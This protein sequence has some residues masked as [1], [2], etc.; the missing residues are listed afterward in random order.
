V[1]RVVFDASAILAAA[2]NEAG[3][4]IV[5]AGLADSAVSTVNL[6]EAHGKLIQRGLAPGDAW[7]AALSFGSEVFPF[8]SDQ[9]RAAGE[10]VGVTRFLGLSLGDRSCLALAML[11]KAP[12]YTTD[13]LWKKLHIGVD[14]HLLR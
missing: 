8:D 13:R 10:M 14:I 1:S 12:V 5:I 11:L 7:E 6:A 4:D 2:N 9:A 3:A